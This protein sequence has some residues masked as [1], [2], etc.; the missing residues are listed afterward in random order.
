MKK[1]YWFIIAVVIVGVLVYVL[2]KLPDPQFDTAE[3]PIGNLFTMQMP[4]SLSLKTDIPADSSE[5]LAIEKQAYPDM[6][7]SQQL[8]IELMG[9]EDAMYDEAGD[10][11]YFSHYIVDIY[12]GSSASGTEEQFLSEFPPND[13]SYQIYN[14]YDTN[15]PQAQWLGMI[16]G[17]GYV[18]RN[19]VYRGGGPIEGQREDLNV[20]IYSRGNIRLALYIGSNLLSLPDADKLVETMGNSISFNQ[21]IVTRYFETAKNE[22]G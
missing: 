2:I 12:N 10:A 17:D 8:A 9:N 16:R 7:Y 22:G 6:D 3:R 4:A 14:P 20:V 15:A 13:I 18:L 21:N 1:R 11:A 19:A 5:F